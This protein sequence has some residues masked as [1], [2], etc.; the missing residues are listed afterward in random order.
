MASPNRDIGIEIK[1]EGPLFNKVPSTVVRSIANGIVKN[2]ALFGEADVKKQLYPGH[3]VDTGRLRRSISGYLVKDFQGQ[4][5]PGSTNYAYQVEHGWDF[6]K[7]GYHMFANS[8]KS[9]KQ[10]QSSD[11]YDQLVDREIKRWLIN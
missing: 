4:V 8:R 10:F 6:G 5:D 7:E 9:I 1:T 3:G 2:V 11:Q